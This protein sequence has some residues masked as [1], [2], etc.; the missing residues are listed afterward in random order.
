V[1]IWEDMPYGYLDNFEADRMHDFTKNP[2]AFMVDGAESFDTYTS[3]FLA[4]F[5][6]AAQANDGKTIAIFSHGAVIRSTLMRLF[7]MDDL[8][9]LPF[10][11]NTGVCR[12]F[13]DNGQITYDY[14]NDN[15]HIPQE[16]STFYIQRWWRDTD[17]RKEAGLY[18]RS[19]GYEGNKEKIEAILLGQQIGTLILEKPNGEVGHIVDLWLDPAFYGRYYADQLLGEA[20]S[21]FRR[22][23][24]KTIHMNPGTYPDDLFG[25]YDFHPVTGIRSIDTTVF[26]WE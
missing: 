5:K 26:Q 4:G 7:F 17:K 18:F 11:D 15:S 24:C 8:S 23:G 10:S 20:F 25:R 14:L 13:Y 6:D 3:R 19:S 21:R 22:A 9:K 16:L 12:L 1:G 2:P